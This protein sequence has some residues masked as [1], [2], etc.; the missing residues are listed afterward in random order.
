MKDNSMMIKMKNPCVIGG[1]R[2]QVDGTTKNEGEDGG[3]RVVKMPRD[4]GGLLRSLIVGGRAYGNGGRRTRTRQTR[5][6][7]CPWL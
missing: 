7:C 1:S 4:D 3:C 2:G 6:E 5:D